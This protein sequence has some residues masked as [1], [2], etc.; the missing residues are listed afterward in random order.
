VGIYLRNDL[1]EEQNLQPYID[2]IKKEKLRDVVDPSKTRIKSSYAGIPAL[3]NLVNTKIENRAKAGFVLYFKDRIMK[4]VASLTDG[5][6]FGA[7][8]L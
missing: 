7:T 6:D 2:T 1:A 4:K 5:M 8:S 3:P